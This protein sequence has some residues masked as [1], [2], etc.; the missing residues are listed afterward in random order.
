MTSLVLNNW[1][2]SF[3]Y[4]SITNSDYHLSQETIYGPCHEKN[5][6]E[7]IYEPCHEK[8]GLLPMR[9]QRNR[10]AS[11]QL[12]ADLRLCFCYSNSTIPLVLIIS[13]L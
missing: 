7:T 12:H 13:S 8:T 4:Y 6:Q 5:G 10:S 3:S 1:A 2:Q 11:Q 9:N